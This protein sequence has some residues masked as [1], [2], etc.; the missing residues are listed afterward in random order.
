MR[1]T[2]FTPLRNAY[3]H[4]RRP[5]GREFPVLTILPDKSGEFT[6]EIESLLLG[7]GTHELWVEDETTGVTSNVAKFDVVLE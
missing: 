7:G 4:L 1:G 2:G 3:S 6:H 5:D